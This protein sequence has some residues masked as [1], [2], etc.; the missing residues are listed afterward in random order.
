M[1]SLTHMMLMLAILVPAQT[2]AGSAN[3]DVVAEQSSITFSATQVGQSFTGKFKTFEAQIQFDPADLASAHVFATIDMRSVDAN[4]GQRNA[5]LPTPD[6]FAS[7]SFPAA[8][9]EA[10]SFTAIDAG[11]YEARGT[12]TI[13]GIAKEVLLPFSLDIEGDKASM[14]GE[15]EIIRTDFGVGQGQWQSGQWVGLEVK[16]IVE[17]AATRASE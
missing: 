5:A 11:K 10:K 14:H 2:W 1:R 15:A 16:I 7:K 3:W 13:R 8:T 17:I 6:W 4:D 9:F 12:L